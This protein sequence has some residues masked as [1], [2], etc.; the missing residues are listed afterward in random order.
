MVVLEFG[1]SRHSAAALHYAVWCQNLGMT[2][3]LVQH[4]A[5]VNILD[6]LGK[7]PLHYAAKTGWT[8]GLIYLLNNCADP[9]AL[10][11]HM[12]TALHFAA[13]CSADSTQSI[14]ALLN[15]RVSLNSADSDGRT[16]L[17]W[18][19]RKGNPRNVEFLLS[20]RNN[21]KVQDVKVGATPLYYAC[22]RRECL[23]VVDE[24]I[25]IGSDVNV[26]TKS[27][28]TALHRAIACDCHSIAR[29]LIQKR[30]DVTTPNH[31]GL[32][33]SNIAIF[34]YHK[35]STMLQLFVHKLSYYP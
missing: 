32:S 21:V 26:K 24:L 27:G 2:K 10:T 13:G 15:H 4:G 17:H 25:R 33:P 6:E 18:A 22:G 8:F 19:C 23:Q 11:S 34:N 9:M 1:E 29:L 14:L 35:N 7:T 3:L 31:V 20:Y 5:E 28:N 16:P 12:T 30:S